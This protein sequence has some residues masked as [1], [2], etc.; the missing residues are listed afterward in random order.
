MGLIAAPQPGERVLPTLNQDGTRRWLRPKLARGK[1][2]RRRLVAAWTLMLIFTALPY[3]RLGGKPMVLLDIPHRQFTLFGRTFLP[4]DTF[5][6]MLL[7][8]GIFVAIFLITAVLGRV[9]CGWACP[10][11]VYMEFLYRPLERWIEGGRQRQLALDAGGADGRRLLKFGLF[12]LISAFLANTFVAYFVGIDRLRVWITSSPAEHPGAFAVM[13]GTTLLMFFDFAYFREQT[14]LVACPYGRFQSVLLDRS[15]LIV[16]YD[17]RRGEPRGKLRS[18]APAGLGDCI[19]CGNCVTTCPTGIDIRDG[20]QMEC[21]ACTQCIDACDAVMEKVGR[22]LGLIRYTSQAE[23]EDGRS[24]FLRPRLAVYSAIL[25]VIFGVLG[26][27]LAEKASA[28]VTLLRGLGAPYTVLPSG[29]ISNQLRLKIANRTGEDREYTFTVDGAPGLAMIAPEN[30]LAVAA[31]ES[32]LTAAFVTLPAAAFAGGEARVTL[33][34]TD[35]GE[36]SA[37]LPYRLL[38]PETGGAP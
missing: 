24:R 7:L 20:L 28:D 2:Y 23:L 29:E 6:L 27:S 36:F 15:S 4:T 11:T 21:V 26:L 31:G 22:P 14:C 25:V 13:L 8:V 18:G 19:D 5:L 12:F 32:A 17:E 35:G 33:H 10:Q 30:P 37:D 34:V 3:L 1:H 16:G 9:W 38:G